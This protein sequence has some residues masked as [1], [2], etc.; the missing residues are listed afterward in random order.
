MPAPS[1]VK[2][3]ARPSVIPVGMGPDQLFQ[4]F[5]GLP[6]PDPVTFV[7]S[8][9][10]LDRGTI[11]Y[12]R[13]ATLLK[14]IFLRLD[15]L[16]EYD[17]AV[18]D[19]WEQNFRETG[20][21]G[22][23]PGVRRRMAKL[24]Q[25]G[26]KWFRE[27]LLVMGRRAG[28]GHISGLSMAYVLWNYM[29]KGD[30]QRFYGVDRD[31]KLL[32][33][34]FAGK[35]DQAKA[36]VWQDAVNYITGSVCFIP[37]IRAP[38]QAEKLSIYAPHDFVRMRKLSQQGV[39]PND[40]NLATFELVPK[41][42]TLMAGRGPTSFC[43]DPSTPVLTTDLWWKPIG[44]LEAGEHLIGLDEYPERKGAQRKL[45]DAEVLKVWRTRKEALRLTFAD[46]SSVVCSRDHR[47]LVRDMGKGGATHWR[48]AG[49]MNVGNH[50]K[51]LVD[52][53][54]EE[55]TR[56][57]GYLAGIYDGE[58]CISGY[59]GR[60]G[61]SVF[62]TQ[63]EG[64]V[65]DET[66]RLLKDRGFD[67]QFYTN[68]TKTAQQWSLSGV[69]ESMT[70]LGS[71]RPLR[72]MPK[73]RSVWEG[74]APR[75]GVTPSGRVRPDSY[76]TIISIEE[77]P[78]QELVDIETSTRT[79]IANG[80][81][82]HN[83]Q[84]YD[85]MAH[86]VAS[87]A[88]RSAE[89]VYGAATPSLDQFGF[90]GFIIEPSSPWQ[91][92]GQFY[93]NYCNALLEDEEGEPVYPEM[94]MIQLASWDI[95]KDWEIAHTLPVF[96]E[97]YK[98]DL[99]EYEGQP[100]LYF[101]P[102]RGAIQAYDDQMARL[103][104]SNPETFRVERRSHFAVAM[105]AYLK[106]E[107]VR[108]IF[109]PWRER[110]ENYGAPQLGM[111]ERGRLDLDYKAHG[112]PSKSNANFGLAMAHAEPGPDGRLHVV[113][114]KIHHFHPGDFEDH[115]V[116][117]DE[118]EEWIWDNMLGPFMPTEMTFDQF[119]SAQVI[120][121]L[122]K[123]SR[124]AALPKVTQVYEKTATKQ[125]NWK[126]AEIFKTAVYMGWVHAPWYEQAE[127]ELRF[128]QE[129]NGVVDHPDSGPVQTKDVADAMMECV[130]A[131]IGDQIVSMRSELGSM[132]PS[133]ALQ[134]GVEPFPGMSRQD[135]LGEA[136]RTQDQVFQQLGG[137]GKSR[138]MRP[139]MMRSGP[140]TRGRR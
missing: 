110:L 7:L 137:F 14:I 124:R 121:R 56:E 70:F 101:N 2:T 52:P 66:L 134:G 100:T 82:S 125:H 51:S 84:A 130:M 74:V 55:Q 16:T 138:G 67:P 34:V 59:Q 28:K 4:L 95:Y 23:V 19:E 88:N 11:M 128:L 9:N 50:I 13:Q 98:G 76:K 109:A 63:N 61:K 18:I 53:W 131:L 6:V 47:W 113:F 112:D 117:Y 49:R 91:M 104:Q 41:E 132:R 38:L 79:F 27:T 114:D 133:G 5:T 115:I 118:I 33:M 116:D 1:P 85:E 29:A 30:P 135:A 26:R 60:A 68:S 45:R 122:A 78:E 139:D 44:E 37:Y 3:K 86:V 43:L 15:L 25:E 108:Q 48:T 89:E 136:P 127:L 83:C 36:T 69:A 39:N 12:P 99:G 40:I 126:R 32:A 57:A 8:E 90:D 64:A 97:G 92:L 123:R 73:S 31:K 17:H 120:Q 80:L 65:L 58:G 105:D 94:L 93:V 87:G 10:Y 20:D 35:R 72:L 24:R 42:S 103:E 77:L 140:R 21:N 111:Q 106:E 81:I 102:L 71:I 22:I 96:P 62:V 75:G 46:G 129:K 54:E 107:K 119:N